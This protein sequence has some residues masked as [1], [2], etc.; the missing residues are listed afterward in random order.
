MSLEFYT[1]F[2]GGSAKFIEFDESLKQQ[3][4]PRSRG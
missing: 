2:V 1:T 3:R 4:A